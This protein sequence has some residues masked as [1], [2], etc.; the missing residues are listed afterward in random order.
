MSNQEILLQEC[1]AVYNMA[2]HRNARRFP[3]KQILSAA[4]KSSSGRIV[5]LQ[6]AKQRTD[7]N[8]CNILQICGGDQE[9]YILE[10]KDG[11]IKLKP[12][13]ECKNCS[14]DA[15]WLVSAEYIQDVVENSEIY[16]SN[17]AKLDWGWLH[18][19]K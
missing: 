8:A 4:Q 5:E 18:A 14:C 6:I 7:P 9:S 13:G 2:L 1:F 12:H 19:R 17:P 3:F 10:M 15:T 11:D 16:V